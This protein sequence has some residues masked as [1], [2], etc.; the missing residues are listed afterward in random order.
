LIRVLGPSVRHTELVG[1]AYADSTWNK[2]NS[3][4]NTFECFANFA[5]IETTWPFSKEVVGDFIHWATFTRKLSPS[6]IT[7]YLSHFKLVHEL[8]GVDSANLSSFLCKTQIRGAQNLAFYDEMQLG[9]R[10]VMNL[11]LLKILGH[12]IANANWSP[13][14]KIVVWSAYTMAFFGSFRFG[15]IVS[16]DEDSFNKFETLLWK[17]IQIFDDGSACIHNKI[18][19]TRTAKGEYIS[20]FE[21]PNHNCCPVE[22]LKCLKT[23]SGITGVESIPVYKFS[24]GKFLTCKKANELLIHFL[25]PY[26]GNEAFSYSCKSF[27][28]A[29]PS[30]LS[31][32]PILEN[33]AF[34]KKWGRWSSDAYERYTRLNHKAKKQIFLQFA[35]ALSEL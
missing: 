23:L 21:F 24:N 17:D 3:A 13:H 15:E 27:R 5:G 30:A 33:E 28:A 32:F 9:N 14:S 16:S 12:E 4:L 34:I 19:K 6:T 2:I 20:L 11:H 29:L 8:R 26:L 1:A 18:P 35:R 10:K 7:S 31:S 22:A 25:R